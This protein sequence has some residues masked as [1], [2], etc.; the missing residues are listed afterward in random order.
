M[1][2]LNLT[3]LPK[4]GDSLKATVENPRGTVE[5]LCPKENVKGADTVLRG[6]KGSQG[7]F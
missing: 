3:L 1:A 4:D 2:T 6:S 7:I 5:K